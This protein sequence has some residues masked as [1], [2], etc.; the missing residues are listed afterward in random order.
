VEI[1]NFGAINITFSEK[2]FVKSTDVSWI[3]ESVLELELVPYFLPEYIDPTFLV[4]DWKVV[5]YENKS[6]ILKVNFTNPAYISLNK[7]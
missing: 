1:S 3:N 7:V 6:L 2:M 5:S 4:F